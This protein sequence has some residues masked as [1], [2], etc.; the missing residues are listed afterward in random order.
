MSFFGKIKQG[1]GIGTASLELDIPQTFSRDGQEFTGKVVLTAKS[2]QKVKSV[3]VKMTEHYTSGSGENKTT[4]EY[5]LGEI[6]LGQSFDLAAEE[7]REIE[8][9][10]P[11]S[12]KLSSTQALAGKGGVLGAIGKVASMTSNERSSYRID[13]SADLEGVALDPNDARTITLQ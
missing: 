7:R 1:L 2:A 13:A 10:L 3:K 4:R 12:L 11:Y 5:V 8:F 6:S 9:K